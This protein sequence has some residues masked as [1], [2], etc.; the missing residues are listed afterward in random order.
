M[1]VLV[2]FEFKNVDVYSP[3]AELILRDIAKACEAFRAEVCADA[4]YIDHS[5]V[6]LDSEVEVQA[7]AEAFR[8]EEE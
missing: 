6:M 7:H 5:L 2:A 8:K 3:D 1:K 4:C